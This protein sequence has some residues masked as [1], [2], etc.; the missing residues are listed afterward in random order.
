MGIAS[1]RGQATERP[2][3]RLSAFAKR[4]HAVQRHVAGKLVALISLNR[5]PKQVF[6]MQEVELR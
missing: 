2:C 1:A 5:A 6:R 4:A 3:P